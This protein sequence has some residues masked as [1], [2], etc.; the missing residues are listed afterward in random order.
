MKEKITD[1]PLE[2]SAQVDG[3]SAEIEVKK[4]ELEELPEAQ[5]AG[6]SK[7]RAQFMKQCAQINKDLV[8]TSAMSKPQALVGCAREWNDNIMKAPAKRL[9]ANKPLM[10]VMK[11]AGVSSQV[12]AALAQSKDP[13][14]KA[15][16]TLIRGSVDDESEETID[17][18]KV[19]SPNREEYAQGK[20]K[21][22][23]DKI[24]KKELKKDTK[25]EKEEHEKDAV[26]DDDSKI[27]KLKKGKPSVKKDVEIHDLKKDERFD[28][29]NKTKD[30]KAKAK[31][32][33]LPPWLNKD[34]KELDKDD[35]KEKEE[36]EKDAVKDDKKQVKDLKKDEKEDKKAEK[37]DK[38]S[39]AADYSKYWE[40]AAERFG[41]KKRSKL[42]DSDFLDPKNR[43]FPVM[44]CKNVS[45]AV[46]T[47]G[48]YK[49][50]MS[51]ETFKRK[52]TSR[53][54][55]LGCEG[56][57]PKNWKEK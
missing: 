13:L 41:G 2:T 35:K 12:R 43:S 27:K 19:R 28:R 49:G 5:A 31:K 9:M 30:A 17:W 15:L 50:P 56:S 26:K 25:K 33:N 6:I 29:E 18:E 39:K 11:S 53:A 34:K 16:A 57:L 23:W 14:P 8:D 1:Q 38:K 46:S 42:K 4:I 21:K 54:K 36:H 32:G 20:T 37:K 48:M 45:A 55:K 52:L 3:V 40:E 44:S 24:D 7:I 10:N 51:F 22:Q 47:W